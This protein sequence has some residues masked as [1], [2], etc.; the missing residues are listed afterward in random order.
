[1]TIGPSF[2][3]FYEKWVNSEDVRQRSNYPILPQGN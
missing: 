1:M 2:V 3:D